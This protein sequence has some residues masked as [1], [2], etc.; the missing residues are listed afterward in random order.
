MT[1]C[2]ALLLLAA[3]TILPVSARAA[4]Y[5]GLDVSVWQG[6]IDFVQVKAYGKEVVYIRAGYGLSED[7]RFRE[8]A[9][10][11]RAAG[12]KVGFYFYV[13]ASDQAQAREQAAYFAGLLREQTYECRPAVDFEQYG[14]LSKTELNEIALAFAGTLEGQTGVIPVF[15]TDSSSAR[16]IWEKDLTRY[17]LWIADYGVSQPESL[18]LWSE[19]VGFQYEDNGRVP[20]VPGN[21]DLDRFTDGVFV[22]RPTGLPFTDVTARD[23]YYPAV[24]SLY[25]RGL[26]R[27]VAPDRFAPDRP[28]QRAEAVT[29]LYRL[30]GEPPVSGPTG[31][32]DVPVGAWYAAPVRWAEGRRSPRGSHPGSLPRSRE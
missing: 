7:A 21:V 13:T 4:E 28:A 17:P 30:A 23:W 12:L 11:A 22:E 2:F 24:K 15:Y 16:S 5:R 29:L 9:E 19:W 8:N 1:R 27:G 20:G 26:I 6:E 32:F 3:L 25:D 18:G 10:K 31:F 14:S